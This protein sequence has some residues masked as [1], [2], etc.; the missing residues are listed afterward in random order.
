[1]KIKLAVTLSIAVAMLSG[2]S[3]M[4]PKVIYIDRSA[5]LKAFESSQHQYPTH[6]RNGVIVKNT[7]V[8][9][10]REGNS[11]T[12]EKE[13]NKLIHRNSWNLP[14]EAINQYIKEKEAVKS[15]ILIHHNVEKKVKPVT[16]KPPLTVEVK[17]SA[18]AKVVAVSGTLDLKEQEQIKLSGTLPNE[19]TQHFIFS[20]KKNELIDESRERLRH[21]SPHSLLYSKVEIII[22]TNG[23]S[24]EA[25]KERSNIVKDELIRAGFRK[26]K[27][28]IT[29][30]NDPAK[31]NTA[32]V[33]FSEK[34][35]ITVLTASEAKTTDSN[36]INWV[37]IIAGRD[38]KSW[39]SDALK[40]KRAL[41]KNGTEAS[42]ITILHRKQTGTK[43][44]ALIYK[45]K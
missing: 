24:D 25:I 36:G 5:A 22:Y 35:D 21:I 32:T 8:W 44:S 40:V 30:I 11:F 18:E 6:I 33:N 43:T 38:S 14:D 7:N 17:K 37:R 39:L 15:Q 13:K 28:K 31:S 3:I 2:C 45:N 42:K 9:T 1:M 26:S 27:T 41:L 4:Q 29:L 12:T 19:S 23:I 16:N 20:N 10:M 34:L